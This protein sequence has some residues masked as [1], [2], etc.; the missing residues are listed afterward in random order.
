L[1]TTEMQPAAPENTDPQVE[2]LPRHKVKLKKTM[3]RSCNEKDAKGKICGG[4]L[5]RWFY[6]ADVVEKEC[7]DVEQAWGKSREVYRCEHCK[8]LYLPGPE[9]PKSPTVPRRISSQ[10]IFLQRNSAKSAS[11]A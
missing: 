8:T 9:E 4:H 7:G 10:K 11:S 3:Q 5:K 6:T 1:A 2:Q